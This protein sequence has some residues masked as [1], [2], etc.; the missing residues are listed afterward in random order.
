MYKVE[1]RAMATTLPTYLI[2]AASLAAFIRYQE[3]LG[4]FQVK[5]IALQQRNEQRSTCCHAAAAATQAPAKVAR[6]HAAN[7]ACIH[8]HLCFRTGLGDAENEV[9]L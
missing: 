4:L 5:G 2:K 6:T 9:L 1:E 7:T 3:I 8:V